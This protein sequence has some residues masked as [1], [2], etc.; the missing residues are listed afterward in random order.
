[1]P[2]RN[3][4]FNE[5]DV[6]LT[7][8]GRPVFALQ[9]QVPT[10]RDLVPGSS[11][12]DVLQLEQSLKR[13]GFDPGLA[14]GIYDENTSAAVTAWYKSKKWESFGP[15]RDQIAN[16][17]ALEREWGDAAKAKAA[18]EAASAAAGLAVAAAR[19]TAAHN[20]R[21]AAIEGATRLP[22]GGK[23][24]TVESERAKAE[25]ANVAA[26]AELEVQIA[27]RALIV[28]DPR[29]PES[30][31]AAADAK[32]QVAR[33][34]KERT[35]LEGELAIQAAEREAKMATERAE[36]AQS[37]ERSAQLEGQKSI[38]AALD[39]QKLAVLEAKM[40][41]ERA[42]QLAADL[43]AV[44]RRLGMQ[45]PA[46]EVVFIRSFPVRVEEVT[47]VVGGPAT[48][49]VMSV[50]DNQLAIDS[51]L[52]LD[53]APLVKSG[54]R[55]AIDEQALGVKATGAVE[56]VADTPGTRGVDGF[57]VYLGVG[58]DATPVRLEGLSVRLTIPIESTKGAVTAIP[59]SALS[60]AT[61]GTSRIQVESN[62][63]L[64]YIAVK[65]GLSANGYVEVTP[66]KGK[67][68]PG[69][70]VVVGFN[71]PAIRDLK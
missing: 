46:D 37:A 58:I 6:I 16:V 30:A 14:D 59:V 8:S 70:L 33:A 54:M 47:G 66:L 39:A 41:T 27:D 21:A 69:Q 13:L 61:D 53:A 40:A 22:Q 1:V 44:K 4:Q 17:R 11:G 34:A 32:V 62:G 71:S 25:H 28:L 23:A 57:H 12:D 2:L 15:T 63:V 48:G 68:S 64:E 7:A 20:I 65:P 9:G 45:V 36:L 49:S 31:R 55:V 51:S 52:P 35:K 38:G 29:Q 60:L 56:A 24:L 19:A 67:L 5:G 26:A 3:T 42:D 43:S 18:A 50:T 10:Y